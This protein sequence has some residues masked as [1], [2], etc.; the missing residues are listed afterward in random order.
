MSCLVELYLMDP[1]STFRYVA[2]LEDVDHIKVDDVKNFAMFVV[3]D[4][5]PEKTRGMGLT[6]FKQTNIL[7]YNHPM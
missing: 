3:G 2:Q 5:N 1:G 6:T 7:L 4:G